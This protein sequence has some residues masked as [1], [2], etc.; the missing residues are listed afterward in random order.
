MTDTPNIQREQLEADVLIIGAGPGGLSCALHLANLIEKH[1][2]AKKSPALSA[3]NIYVLEKG[4][5][6]GAHQLS[7][8]IMDPRGLRELVPDFETTAPLDS[9]VTGDAAYYFTESSS[10]K[11]PI[12]PP[13]LQN[14]GNYVVS[15]NK[16]VK[17]L[18]GLVEKK[19]VN[20]FTQFAGRELLYEKNGI[21]GVLTE[22]KGVDK[23]GKPKD[24]FTPGYELHAK[25]TVLAEGPRGSLTKELVNKLKLDGL[26]PQVYGLGIKE[27]WDVQP[28]K[29]DTGYVAHTL[30]WPLRSDLYGGGWVYGLQNNRV[31]L[32]MVVAL[33][34]HDPFF[35]PHEAFQKYKT[36]PFVKNILEGGKLIRY[37]AK[38]VPYGGW[39][40]MPRSYVDGGLIIGDSASLLNSQRLKGI[41]TAIK[42]GMLAAE[43]IYEALCAGDTSAKTLS[44]YPQKIEASWIKKELWEVRNFHQAFHGGLYSGLLQAGLQFVTGGRGLSD[45]MHS[46]PGYQE[47]SKLN[48]DRSLVDQ[49]A[50]FKGDGKLAFDRLTDVY[51]SGTRHEE[52][53]PCHLVVLE[54][55][56]CGDR[57]V[58][59]YGNP[60]QYFC[61]AAV[62]EM[63]TEKGEP[64]L[65]IN[66]SNCVHC[67]TCDIA[68]PYQI[69]N[70]V[71]PEGGGPNYEGM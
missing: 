27:L 26:N 10:Y 56:I 41:H 44:A 62:Y 7:G 20:L 25:V 32:G 40:S 12:T 23:N 4:R 52:D 3:E 22:D 45:P 57:C 21:A 33:E 30:G 35:D 29:I 68:D 66:A 58:R 11:L 24:N 19:G 17:W 18:G 70:W 65:K 14:H 34:Y 8:A 61:P 42:S 6:I 38:T 71:P 46:K 5:E 13:P 64:R 37:G 39:Y 9:P 16:L 15:L 59:E 55:N 43:T 60:C 53:Q 31:S 63:V 36:H 28:G 50:R 54:P 49:S 51:H 1:N 47:Y 48:R 69:I 2:E 67:K